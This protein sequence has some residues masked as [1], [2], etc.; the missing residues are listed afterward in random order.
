MRKISTLV[1][2][3]HLLL[4]QTYA[5]E[6]GNSL[7]INYTVKPYMAYRDGFV[8]ATFPIQTAEA[9]SANKEMVALARRSETKTLITQICKDDEMY[10]ARIKILDARR[11]TA[12]LG[13]LNSLSVNNIK[14]K[15]YF[16]SVPAMSDED[17]KRNSELYPIESD[18]PGW[19]EYGYVASV[20]TAECRFSGTVSII[21]S[22][23]YEVYIDGYLQDEYSRSELIK[24][25]WVIT[26]GIGR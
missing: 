9:Q 1:L 21:S 6:A 14:V 7:K 20:I 8:S 11:G 23:A 26:D 15:E 10:K 2:A 5:A 25:K 3:L 4:I 22:N 19:V 16:Q 24:K 17:V 18:W 12:G 13:N